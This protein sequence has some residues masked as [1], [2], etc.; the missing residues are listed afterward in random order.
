MRQKEMEA[1]LVQNLETERKGERF[2]LIE[3][4]M[5]PEIPVSPNRK[6]IVLIGAVLAIGVSIGLLFLLEAT[7][8]RIRDRDHVVQLLGVPPL[9]IVPYMHVREERNSQR[10][11]RLLIMAAVAST[12]ILSVLLFHLFIRPLDLVWYEILQRIGV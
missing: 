5:Q 4:P 12:L 1:Q 2:T 11:R 8:T 7:D 3:P 9:A 6:L 10:R